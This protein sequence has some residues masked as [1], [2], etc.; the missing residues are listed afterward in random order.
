MFL[1]KYNFYYDTELGIDE[2]AKMEHNKKKE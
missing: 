1:K 2:E